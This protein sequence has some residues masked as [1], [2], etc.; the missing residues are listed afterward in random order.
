MFSTS[1]EAYEVLL[2]VVF[3]LEPWARAPREARTLATHAAC[4]NGPTN[5]ARCEAGM[6]SAAAQCRQQTLD[7]GILESLAQLNGANT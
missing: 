5:C 6:N 4:R 2:R 3:L 1:H 7:P